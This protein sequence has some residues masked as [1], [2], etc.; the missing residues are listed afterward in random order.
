NLT[1]LKELNLRGNYLSITNVYMP[2]GNLKVL[3]VSCNGKNQ[4]ILVFQ[5]SISNFTLACQSNHQLQINNQNFKESITTL[6][7]KDLNYVPRIF[8]TEENDSRLVN[9]LSELAN[10]RILKVSIRSF[11]FFNKEFY[12]LKKLEI[13]KIIINDYQEDKNYDYN[14]LERFIK[15]ANEHLNIKTLKYFQMPRSN[16][17][18]ALLK[19]RTVEVF[20]IHNCIIA[21]EFEIIPKMIHLQYLSFSLCFFDINVESI[22]LNI[23]TLKNI[24]FKNNIVPDDMDQRNIKIK[25]LKTTEI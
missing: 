15:G 19:L 23:K 10:I 25:L 7:I 9:E 24:K 21:S 20:H 4:P 14:L 3:D 1:N 6:I 2:I 11:S 18:K 5:H 17:P 8:L 12:N 16:I 22:I 13:L